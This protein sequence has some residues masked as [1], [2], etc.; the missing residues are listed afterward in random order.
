MDCTVRIWD[1]NAGAVIRM[2]NHYEEFKCL[3]LR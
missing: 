3:A 1:Y 2:F